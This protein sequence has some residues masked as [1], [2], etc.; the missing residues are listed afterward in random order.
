MAHVRRKFYEI[1]QAEAS[2]LAYEAMAR[3]REL[4]AIEDLIRGEPPDKRQDLRESRAGPLL[5]QFRVWLEA[6]LLQLPR[7]SGLAAAIRYA[8][9]RW[10]ALTRYVDD[11]R[12]E[13]DNNTAERSLR[14]VALGR[15]NFLFVGSIAGGERAAAMYS[16]IGTAQLN[17]LD[18]EAYLRHVLSTIA[19]HPINRIE[20]LLPWNVTLQH[21]HDAETEAIAA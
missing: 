6:T 3:I 13:I 2:P 12:I 20:A 18:P 9:E 10:T 21:R 4:Y 8:L 11:G 19:E 16:L 5:D 7:K 1:A 17:G 14:P 15:K